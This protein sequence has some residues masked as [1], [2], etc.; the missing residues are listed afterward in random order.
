MT[1][2]RPRIPEID[3]T[4]RPPIIIVG[5]FFSWPS[6]YRELAGILTE[7]S[8]L[9]THI[10]PLT[11]VDW[12]RAVSLGRNGQLV[13]E[14][15]T[16]VDKALLTSDSKKA[17][18]V[19]HSA[20]GVASRVYLGGDP[21]FGGRRYSGHRRVS[22]LITLG[23][24]HLVRDVWPLSLLRRANEL[25]PGALH[26]DSIR[27]ISVAGTAVDGASSALA[28]RRYERMCGKRDV[29]GDGTVP[30]ESALLPGSEQ[31]VFD[32]LHH[33]PA[34]ELWYGHDRET[35]ERWWPEELTR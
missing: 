33:D 28:G 29:R 30:L 19:A 2:S 7:L 13:F 34:K 24:P 26:A 11:L 8:G 35:I 1:D 9:P 12:A 31:L 23:S 5:S 27:Y 3:L 10:V 21:P 32:D 16:T 17:I 15:A 22:H 20:G 4:K 14:V 25:F 18:I 6:R